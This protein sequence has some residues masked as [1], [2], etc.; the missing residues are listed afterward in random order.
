[1]LYL[2]YNCLMQSVECANKL[3]E[4]AN[5]IPLF[6]YFKFGTELD[7][8]STYLGKVKKVLGKNTNKFQLFLRYVGK[9]KKSTW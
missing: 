4:C 6:I 3:W 2:K 8:S 9:V 7:D 1:M 5:H